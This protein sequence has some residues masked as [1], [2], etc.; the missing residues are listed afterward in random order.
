[1]TGVLEKTDERSRPRR[2]LHAFVQGSAQR[3]AMRVQ[4]P[5]RSALPFLTGSLL[6]GALAVLLV[7]YTPC[8]TLTVNG[9]PAGLVQS[10]DMVAQTAQQVEG[11]I[12]RILG[13]DYQLT[14]D[15][16]YKLQFSSKNEM[17]GYAALSETL[18]A[19]V[20]DIKPAYVLA[21]D[22][23]ELGASTDKAVLDAA[24]S[25]VETPFVREGT[26]EVFYANEARI[27]RK[28]IPAEAVFAEEGQLVDALHQPVAASTIYEVQKGDTVDTIGARFGMSRAD[29]FAQNPSVAQ[30][31]A[32]LEGQLVT[33]RKTLPRLSVC[34]V[35]ELSYTRTMPS[36]VQEIQDPK[37]FEGERLVTSQG[38]DGSEYILSNMTYVNGEEQYE[39]ILE[40]EVLA[41]V[42][43]TVVS[44][45]TKARPAEIAT[46]SLQWPCEGRV[47]SPFG[48]RFIFGGSS[49]HSGMDIANA[50]GTSVSAADGGVVTFVG[51]KG[52]YGNLVKIDHGNGIET[53]Y[54]HNATTA[55]SVGQTVAKGEYIAG[56]GATGRA[57]GN[58]CHF[59]VRIGG[60][61]VNPAA[62]LG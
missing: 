1:M 54:A 21:V 28:Y 5:L 48:Y 44:V 58:H 23:L 43:P 62:Y 9:T 41:E 34:T 8:Y 61:A 30:T 3:E 40:R 56:M 10:R 60:E 52:S 22:G 57:T 59:E 33:V 42:T 12:S 20:P 2:L 39:E 19:A 18:L 47:T 37:L 13:R 46:G 24:L 11:Q 31:A 36:P 17:L 7:I 27:T 50:Y 15:Y 6:L 53:Y 25:T 14:L 49:F 29:F 51:Y 38:Q 26:K 35:D 45:G 32:P 16:T 55:V 4:R